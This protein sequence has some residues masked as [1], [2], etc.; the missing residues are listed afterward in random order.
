MELLFCPSME[1]HVSI[2]LI[3]M[4]RAYILLRYSDTT[5]NRYKGNHLLTND[6]IVVETVL[7]V[8]MIQQRVNLSV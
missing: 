7:Y 3:L 5:L 1:A 4:Y 6:I 2:D 8:T